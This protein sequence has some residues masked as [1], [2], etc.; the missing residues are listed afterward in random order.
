MKSDQK[1]IVAK[2]SEASSEAELD[3]IRI[4]YLGRN[5]QITKQLR[6][7]GQLPADERGKAGARA[8]IL[9]GQ[10]ELSLCEAK[11]KLQQENIKAEISSV[12]LDVTAP[13]DIG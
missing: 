5:G 6:E 8:N 4:H 12:T 1:Q 13:A 3:R 10:V 2:I 11:K 9:R 7:I